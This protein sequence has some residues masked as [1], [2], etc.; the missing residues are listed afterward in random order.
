MKAAV[1]GL[2]KFG[3]AVALGL[4]GGGAEVLAVDTSERLV[5]AVV[6]DVAVA[7]AFD[8]TDETSLRA[9]NVGGLDVA[10][11]AMATNFEA[12]VMVTMLCKTLGTRRVFAK[13]LNRMQEQVLRRVGA[14]DIVMPEQDMGQRLAEHLLHDRGMEFVQLPKGFALRRVKVPAAWDGKTLAELDLLGTHR[15]NLVQI[16]RRG[17]DSSGRDAETSIAL[18]GGRETLRAGDRIDVIGPEREVHKLD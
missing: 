1:F 10:V 3:Q 14:D 17:R 16:L 8:A 4:A 15:L 2:G 12:S 9:Y 18:P 7:V 5:E 13:A 6:D 11:V